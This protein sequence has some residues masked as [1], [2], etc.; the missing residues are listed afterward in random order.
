MAKTYY[1]HDAD[2]IPHPGQE[3]SHHRLRLA[4]PRARPQP[5]GL[6]RHVKVG[7]APRLQIHR[8]GKK[9]G[10]EVTT[11]AEDAAKW[12]DVVMVL[13]PTRPQAKVYTD[14]IGP[15]LTAGKL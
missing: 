2:L 12:A 7:L 4:G 14:E 9:A 6:R 11:V 1:D 3:G 5:Q 13:T 8:Q 15:N 10:L